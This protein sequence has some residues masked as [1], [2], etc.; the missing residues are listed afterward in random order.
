MTAVMNIAFWLSVLI[1]FW[2]RLGKSQPW[3]INGGGVQYAMLALV[4]VFLLSLMVNPEWLSNNINEFW[5]GH[6]KNLLLFLMVLS[7]IRS[8][9]VLRPILLAAAAGFTVRAVLLLGFYWGDFQYFFPYRKGFAMDATF[10]FTITA[11]LFLFDRGL[12]PR[13]R[14]A[15]GGAVLVQLIPLMLHGSRTPFLAIAAGLILAAMLGRYWRLLLAGVLV[16]VV[17]VVG[18]MQVRPDLA[19]RYAS[20]FNE[21]TYQQDNAFLERRGIWFVTS[22]LVLE[23]PLLGYGPGWRKLAP[24]ARSKGYVEKLAGSDKRSDILAH[25]YFRD[26]SYG[27]ANPHNLY[28]QVAFEVGLIGLI[29]YL[30]FLMCTLW[31]AIQLWR[32]RCSDPTALALTVVAF[33]VCYVITGFANGLWESSAMLLLMAAVVT[34]QYRDMQFARDRK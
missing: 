5:K 25:N 26:M 18:M 30:A 15:L 27:R 1:F 10:F 11:A 7:S 29:V 6:L 14:W 13:I 17:G 20:P 8:M 32:S 9:Q 31:N 2:Q 16:A 4:V 24:L 22:S 19:A 23:H 21:D 34:N 12:S 33:L 28:M 3:A